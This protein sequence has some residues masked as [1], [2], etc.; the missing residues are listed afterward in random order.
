MAD[1]WFYSVSEVRVDA[2][3]L[4]GVILPKDMTASDVVSDDGVQA[5]GFLT[6]YPFDATGVVVSHEECWP[7]AQAG[8]TRSWMASR[9]GRHGLGTPADRSSVG[10]REGDRWWLVPLESRWASG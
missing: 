1:G 2:Y 3:E 7:V 6:T 8:T 9:H 10:G 4:I 5:A